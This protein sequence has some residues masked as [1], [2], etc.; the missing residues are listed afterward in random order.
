MN[1]RLDALAA[2]SVAVALAAVCVLV[3]TARTVVGAAVAIVAA[4]DLLLIPLP[5][6]HLSARFLSTV[7]DFLSELIYSRTIAQVIPSSPTYRLMGDPCFLFGSSDVTFAI[8]IFM[9]VR[10]FIL[11]FLPLSK[12]CACYM[13]A[14]QSLSRSLLYSLLSKTHSTILTKELQ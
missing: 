6:L 2:V 14:R 12:I 5:I 4:E 3:A 1:L 11:F 8:S 7:A 10:S 13:Q 9:T